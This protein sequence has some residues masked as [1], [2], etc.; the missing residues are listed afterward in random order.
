MPRVMHE[1][2]LIVGA[3]PAGLAT[4]AHLARRG[5]AGL[6]LEQGS[7][8]GGAWQHRNKSLRL[9]TP[10]R[11]SSLP[12]YAVERE[13]GRWLSA[14]AWCDYLERYTER[15]GL[16]VRCN[17]QVTAVDRHAP[18]WS[19]SSADGQVVLADAVVVAT[20]ED[21]L[22]MVPDVP[23]VSTYQ[24]R[25]VHASQFDSPVDHL[26]EEVLVVGAGTSGAEIATW[27]SETGHVD[28][29][30][31]VRTAPVVLPRQL[32]GI[33]MAHL[34]LLAD[35]AGTRL[36]DSVGMA[37]QRAAFGR[38]ELGRGGGAHRLSERRFVRYAPTIDS[39][40]VA[41]VRQG[42]VRIV[43]AVTAFCGREVEL[44]DQRLLR[45]DTV[46]LATGYRPA[47]E[48]LVGHLGILDREGRPVAV[49]ELARLAPG[50]HFVGLRPRIA[51]LLPAG[52]RESKRIA[53]VIGE[54]IRSPL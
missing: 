18:R 4:A 6:V 9:T 36:V 13:H 42:K 48:G 31:S 3:G 51:P 20:G 8:P 41:A 40:F 29:V 35:R 43:P 21:R 19:V 23:G 50:L 26:G 24:G 14:T 47:L 37:F 5:I 44:A 22:A 30:I 38:L 34:G 49:P 15:L 2:V 16:R 1:P 52:R 45:P 53:R 33:P 11:L 28:V 12:Y 10:R 54:T 32:C 46:V 39:G 27:L 25:V 17:A 7:R